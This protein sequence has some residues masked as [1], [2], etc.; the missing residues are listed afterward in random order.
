MEGGRERDRGCDGKYTAFMIYLH[1]RVRACACAC[2]C[3]DNVPYPGYIA[4]ESDPAS[5]YSARLRHISHSCSI[6][7]A[8]P[9][10]D[11]P[12]RPVFGRLRRRE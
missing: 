1:V 5:I 8:C 9:Q 4:H 7:R 6:S 11:R 2:A 10:F 3:L 12:R